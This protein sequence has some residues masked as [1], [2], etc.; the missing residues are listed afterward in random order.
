MSNICDRFAGA[1]GRRRLVEAWKAQPFVG[2]DD[3]L[4]GELAQQCEVTSFADGVAIIQ[5]DQNDTDLYLILVGSVNVE[6]NGRASRVRQA[7][8]YVGELAMIDIHER[9]SA[10]IRAVGEVCVA[11]VG[12]PQ[13]AA[14]ASE[15]PEMWRH[16]AIEIA[17][18][19]R[20]RL[21]DI[22]GKN[23]K[24]VVFIGSSREALP[25]AN[26]IAAAITTPDT[27]VRIWTND[28]VF[29]P[30][31]TAIEALE[32]AVRQSDFA[33]LVFS[34]DDQLRSRGTNHVVPRDNVIFELGLFM[35][36]LG[37]ER[38][39]IVMPRGGLPTAREGWGRVLDAFG[40]RAPALKVPS[41]LLSL[42][43]LTYDA[44]GEPGK[45]IA[46]IGEQLK[47]IIAT[48]GSR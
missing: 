32:V 38:A 28:A 33:I 6:V 47:R 12:E 45:R 15:H 37:R 40:G 24:P 18:R 13:F 4:A 34:P 9:R 14:I 11:K 10:T 46:A 26:E 22:P 16:F 8:A 1:D 30:M 27:D 7:G 20:Q 23:V 17:R 35:G 25:I 43:P 44:S 41:D 31:K 39:F 2:A 21:N 48:D 19:L 5:Q 29:V 42:T 36:A 3:V